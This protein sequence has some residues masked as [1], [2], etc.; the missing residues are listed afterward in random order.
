MVVWFVGAEGVPDSSY[1][2]YSDFSSF[3]VLS[4]AVGFVR[5]GRRRV[6]GEFL[7]S[8]ERGNHRIGLPRKR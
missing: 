8:W 6:Q 5:R 2:S 4:I 3:G 1:E 7:L